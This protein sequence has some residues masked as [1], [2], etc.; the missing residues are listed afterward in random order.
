M[1]QLKKDFK[2]EFYDEYQRLQ[3]YR[4]GYVLFVF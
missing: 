4:N 2:I 3:R 1:K